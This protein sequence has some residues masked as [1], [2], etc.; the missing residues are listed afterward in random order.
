MAGVR[1]IPDSLNAWSAVQREF[2]RLYS[3]FLIGLTPLLI[4]YDAVFMPGLLQH[5]L[6]RESHTP[7]QFL[8][9]GYAMVKMYMHDRRF[10]GCLGLLYGYNLRMHQSSVQ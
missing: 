1:F 10:Y 2:P 5:N 8:R 4:E 9:T 6:L 3:A 7:Y